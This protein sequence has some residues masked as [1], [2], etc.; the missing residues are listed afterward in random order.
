MSKKDI[1]I[2]IAVEISRVILGVTFI[3]SGFVK[4]VDPYG[5]AYKI[6]DYLAAF[7]LSSL[8]FLAMTGSVV[9]SIVEFAMGACMLFGLYRKWNS[10]LTLAVMVFMTLLTLYLAINDPVEDCGC[11]GDALIITNWQ[12]FYKNLVLLACSIIVFIYCERISNFFTGKTYWLAFLYIFIFIGLFAFRNYVLDPLI[13]FRPYKIGANLPELMDVEEG[14]G[15]HE[16]TTL[17]Y[18]KDGVEKE[19][20]EENYPWEDSTW[21]FVRMDTKIINEGVESPIKDFVINKLSFNPQKTELLEQEDITTEVLSDTGYVFLMITPLLEKMN[22]SYLSVF[23]DVETY[24]SDYGYKF[25]CLTA[26]PTDEIMSWANENVINFEFCSMDERALKTMIRSNP[27]LILFK[28]GV[29]INK[30][31]GIAVPE[32]SDL[33]KPLPELPY[34]QLLDMKTEDRK[35]LFY[36]CVVFFLPLLGL[37]GFDALVYRRRKETAE[38]QEETGENITE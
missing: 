29:I 25:Y 26:S 33:A 28:N 23:E 35:N 9:Q 19:F 24:A 1:L 3:F 30:W 6:E 37:K 16:E 11:F 7:N 21:V 34:G 14:K 2:K 17:V 15:R 27:G 4:A 31:A 12:T 38:K 22:D 18:A 20:T 10:R 36:I 5:T 32:E 13:D 8:S